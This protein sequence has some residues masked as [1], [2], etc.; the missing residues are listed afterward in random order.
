MKTFKAFVLSL[1]FIFASVAANAVNGYDVK[2][3]QTNHSSFYQ[4]G[5]NW[6]ERGSDD[7]HK[8]VFQEF[9]RDAW[10]VYLYD[11]ARNV[12]LRLDLWLK[13]VFYSPG[14]NWNGNHLYTITGSSASQIALNGPT[15][16]QHGSYGGYAVRLVKGS[17][18]LNVLRARGIKN[19]DITSIRVPD[20]FQIDTYQHD[21]FGGWKQSYVVD[22]SHV[23]SKNDQLSSVIIK[24]IAPMKNK[25]LSIQR[26]SNAPSFSNSQADTILAAATELLTTQDGSDDIACPTRMKRSGSV[27]TF[28][29]GDGTIDSKAEMNALQNGINLVKAINFC[30]KL[31]PN[32]VGC[33]STPGTKM[34]VI[35]YT[36]NQE[37]MLWAHEY[38]HNTGLSHRSG[39]N[40]LMD[41]YVGTSKRRINQAECNSFLNN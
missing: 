19:D 10:S 15:L 2:Q 32:I 31:A 35:R 18:R 17:Y 28:T 21:N 7:S 20:G 12:S 6:Y 29:T 38:G 24:Q 34:A 22:V 23:G 26:H 14:K 11:S 13:K 25:Y 37:G 40:N 9:S 5:N 41:N 16:Y 30:S 8:F 39:S 1:P 33:A 27:T 3:V 36:S 4:I